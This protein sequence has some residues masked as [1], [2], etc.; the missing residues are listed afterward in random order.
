MHCSLCATCCAHLLWLAANMLSGTY[1][2]TDFHNIRNRAV[3]RPAPEWKP[4]RVV[5]T[6]EKRKTSVRY[7]LRS[8][9]DGKL[10]NVHMKTFTF[11]KHGNSANRARRAAIEYQRQYCADNGLAHNAYRSVANNS[12][13]EMQVEFGSERKTVQF[14]QMHAKQVLKHRW[15]GTTVRG[16]QCVHTYIMKGGRSTRL[17]LHDFIGQLHDCTD[18]VHIDDDSLNNTLI[19]LH[20][21]NRVSMFYRGERVEGPCANLYE[22]SLVWKERGGQRQMGFVAEHVDCM[23]KFHD[24]LTAH[25]Q[26]AV[27]NVNILYHQNPGDP[28]PYTPPPLHGYIARRLEREQKICGGRSSNRLAG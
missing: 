5:G 10:K 3:P 4:G 26:T 13:V 28:V 23:E 19:N 11:K 14:D 21:P 20:S 25:F 2:P 1:T 27:Y 18:V 6:I 17:Y 9:Q 7:K 12:I 24:D 22:A 16:V 8:R 15:T